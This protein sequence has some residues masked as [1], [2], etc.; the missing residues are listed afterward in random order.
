MQKPKNENFRYLYGPVPSRRLG[1]SLG[2]DIIPQKRCTFDCLYCQVGRT[3]KKTIKRFDYVNIGTLKAELAAIAKKDYKINFVTISGSGEPTLHNSLDRIIKAV[4]IVMGK[5]TPICVITNGSLL[6]RRDVREELM[7]ASVV[8]P[9]L[10]GATSKTFEKINAPYK[11]LDYFRIIDGLVRFR[12]EFPGKI[13]LEIMLMEGIND[14]VSEAH[15]FNELIDKINPDRVYVN[16]PIRPAA[17]RI[18]IPNDEVIAAFMNV[19]GKRAKLVRN[20]ITDII[21]CTA[22]DYRDKITQY[23]KRRPASISDLLK[24]FN[25][26]ENDLTVLLDKMEQAGVIIRKRSQQKEYFSYND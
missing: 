21:A 11:S 8:M 2:I 18:R 5:K 3:P 16:L 25:I 6:Y 12:Q 26:S 14:S 10:D 7:S 23:L 22:D 19:L 9:S 15:A 4:K 20:D 13:W 17:R 1:L 24:V